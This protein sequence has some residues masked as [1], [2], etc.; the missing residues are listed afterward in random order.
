MWG[1][2]HHRTPLE[3]CTRCSRMQKQV[4]VCIILGNQEQGV[5]LKPC[6]ELHCALAT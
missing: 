3:H 6:F 2:A 4:I 1:E 5:D